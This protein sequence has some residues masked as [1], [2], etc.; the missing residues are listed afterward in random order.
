MKKTIIILILCIPSLFGQIQ[1][2]RHDYKLT[3]PLSSKMSYSYNQDFRHLAGDLYYVHGDIAFNIPLS[4]SL[5]ISLNYRQ[6]YEASANE[7]KPEYRPHANLKVSTATSLFS[8]SARARIEYR[9][10]NEKRTFRNREIFTL[11]SR[12]SFSSYKLTPYVADE[13]FYDMTGK[14]LNKNRFYVGL[15]IKRFSRLRPT[16]Y[17]LLES[18][19]KSDQWI[20]IN[21]IGLRFAI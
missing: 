11:K 3:R 10:K 6:I 19:L 1:E 21:V 12:Q 15:E 9:I 2:I 14:E 4:Q 7:W 20:G 13:I 8:F 16:I 17:Y 18:K 5:K